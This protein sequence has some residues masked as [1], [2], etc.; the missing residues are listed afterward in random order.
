MQFRF[1]LFLMLASLWSCNNSD[2]AATEAVN[3]E[4]E[5]VDMESQQ[6][7]D[8]IDF[9]QKFTRDSLFQVTH[10]QFPLEVLP[11]NADTTRVQGETIRWTVEDW[12]F[13]RAFTEEKT[14]FRSSFTPFSK[15]VMIENIVHV[16][17]LFK[18]QRRFAFLAD[19]WYLI[20]Y[21]DMQKVR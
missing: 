20:Y 9:Y 8:F 11:S 1:F 7:K 10:V 5:E 17:G 14:G 18:L 15:D 2:S 21:A 13:Q 4:V 19:D 3:Q 6:M 12:R 16:G